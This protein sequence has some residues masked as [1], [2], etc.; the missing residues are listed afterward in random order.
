MS[1]EKRVRADTEQVAARA[2]TLGSVKAG[3]NAGM[4]VLGSLQWRDSPVPG[5]DT[6]PGRGERRGP[7]SIGATLD[8]GGDLRGRETARV[9]RRTPRHRSGNRMIEGPAARPEASDLDESG[10]PGP[11]DIHDSAGADALVPL[12]DL[13]ADQ[14]VA[15]LDTLQDVAV[16]AV[17]HD[18]RYVAAGGSGLLKVGWD[19]NELIGRTVYDVVP[20]PEASGLAAQYQAALAGESRSFRHQ[21]VRS[22]E[23]I[24]QVEIV[25][26][27]E[28]DG[29]AHRAPIV[30][31]DIT[32]QVRAEQALRAREQRLRE[33]SSSSPDML[34]LYSPEGVYLEVSG[35]VSGLFGWEPGELVG[36]SSYDY[37]HPDDIDAIRATH[38]EVV[39]TPDPGVVT[40]RRRRK[41]GSYC[42]IEVIGRALADPETGQ[43]RAIQ[44]TT[45][46]ITRRQAAEQALTV[47]N[48]SLAASNAE[49]ER[50]AAVASHDLRS[51]L[52]TTR[53]LLNLVPDRLGDDHDP[54]VEEIITRA[55]GQLERMAETVDALLD[56]ARLG[57]QELEPVELAAGDLLADVL[58]AIGPE[59]ASADI[60]VRLTGDTVIR[61]DRRQL[62]LLFQNLISNTTRAARTPRPILVEVH[63]ADL[64]DNRGWSL[65]VCDNGDGIPLTVEHRDPGTCFTLEVPEA[66]QQVI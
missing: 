42:W 53:G 57:A 32:A 45:R 39:G 14:T 31:R 44:C 49:L 47:A 22:P 8:G 43:V 46:D 60:D 59:L 55:C 65:T 40:Y 12:V 6:V 20:E 1:T 4:H 9:A 30:A 56:L 10:I 11:T 17:D 64:G 34:A 35:S 3:R 52:A 19:P 62:R 54:L 63:A 13:D 24:H 26:V 29:T 48:A 21:G 28:A 23:S 25:P 37:F 15:W 51:P 16:M 41:D 7:R 61:G 38:D 50:V 58:D 66:H 18:L 33:L 27:P 36:T 5:G 2:V